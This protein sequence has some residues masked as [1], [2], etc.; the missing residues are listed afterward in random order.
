MVDEQIALVK[1]LKVK[2]KTVTFPDTTALPES[3]EDRR[4]SRKAQRE[5]RKAARSAN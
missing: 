5:Q 4:T 3:K 2:G 1:T